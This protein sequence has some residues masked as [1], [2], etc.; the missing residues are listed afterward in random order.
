MQHQLLEI[1]S[2]TKKNTKEKLVTIK[3]N[4][5]KSMA[6]LTGAVSFLLLYNLFFFL[7]LKWNLIEKVSHLVFMY[8]LKLL[9]KKIVPGA[10]KN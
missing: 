6:Y 8:F 10:S 9:T 3:S 2:K 7:I 5:M 4:N 1:V